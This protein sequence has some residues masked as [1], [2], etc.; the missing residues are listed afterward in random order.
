MRDGDGD[1]RCIIAQ[2]PLS[3]RAAWARLGNTTTLAAGT[4]AVAECPLWT[5]SFADNDELNAHIDW[6]LS[7][8][9]IRSA[10]VDGE[11]RSRERK[12]L[13]VGV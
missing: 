1:T 9:A 5:Q 13:E 7:R 6:C 4:A 8:E 10:Q 3:E 2:K 12:T 11:A